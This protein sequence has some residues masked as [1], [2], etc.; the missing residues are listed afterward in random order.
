VLL[1]AVYWTSPAEF[2]VNWAV[3]GFD[4]QIITGKTS[5]RLYLMLMAMILVMD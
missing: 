2:V 1:N 3:A 4:A 5:K